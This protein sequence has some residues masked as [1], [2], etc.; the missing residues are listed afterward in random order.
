MNEFPSL[1]AFE[2]LHDFTKYLKLVKSHSVES[3]Q[4]RK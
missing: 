3:P 1:L 4:R 2:T